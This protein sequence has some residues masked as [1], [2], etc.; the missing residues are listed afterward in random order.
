MVIIYL[1]TLL[2]RFLSSND[3]KQDGCTTYLLSE[4]SNLKTLQLS[5]VQNVLHSALKLVR[6][7]TCH[8]VNK[9]RK[10]SATILEPVRLSDNPIK[11]TAGLTAAI[12]F[13][14]DIENVANVE[15][16]RI[17]VKEKFLCCLYDR[18]LGITV[19]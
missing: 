1:T 14:A 9:V 8:M 18:H 7:L 13:V 12:L 4:L 11:F 5:T 6:P 15:N 16:I 10:T 2:H 19:L 17:Q 3:S